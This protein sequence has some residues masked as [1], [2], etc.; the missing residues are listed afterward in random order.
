MCFANISCKLWNKTVST[1]LNSFK[2]IVATESE[3]QISV[4][5]KNFSIRIL[6]FFVKTQY[7]EWHSPSNVRILVV[8]VQLKKILDLL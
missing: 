3:Q 5:N 1:E 2:K 4:C 7:S 6:K 8:N